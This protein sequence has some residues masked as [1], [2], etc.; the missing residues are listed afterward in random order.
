MSFQPPLSPYFPSKSNGIEL[1]TLLV[2]L[3]FHLPLLKKLK[4]ACCVPPLP[5]GPLSGP[6][7]ILVLLNLKGFLSF[8]LSCPL[9]YHMLKLSL[10]LI[11]SFLGLSWYH[12]CH[13][14]LLLFWLLLFLLPGRVSSAHFVN[15]HA[16]WDLIPST[17]LIL[18]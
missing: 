18:L 16:L 17:L 3:I 9:D 13:F 5:G 10:P 6:P 7:T 8:Y 14:F 2:S 11:I 4:T 1:S 12:N 15:V